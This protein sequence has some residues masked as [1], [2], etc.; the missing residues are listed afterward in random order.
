MRQLLQ[1]YGS[2]LLSC[3]LL[4]LQPVCCSHTL[5]HP[6]TARQAPPRRDHPRVD[7][8]IRDQPRQRVSLSPKGE[9]GG[10]MSVYSALL[11]SILLWV[12][13]VCVVL[14]GYHDVL[15]LHL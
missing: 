1:R 13:V 4:C 11:L 2:N 14:L 9:E 6:G 7:G 3:M 12:L 15:P 8:P 5:Y 10:M